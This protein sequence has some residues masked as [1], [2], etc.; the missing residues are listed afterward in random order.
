MTD[1]TRRRAV[2]TL[3]ATL[4][5]SSLLALLPAST[6]ACSCA[7]PTS[8][9]ETAK[10]P[11]TVIFSG[12][13]LA[14]GRPDVDVA[15][16][17]WFKGGAGPS[18]ALAAD[19]FNDQGG[20]ADCRVPYPA[21]GTSWIFV[22][23]LVPETGAQ[24]HTNLCSLQGRIDTP[25]GQQL[26]AS[27]VATFGEGVSPGH[28]PPASHGPLDAIGLAL[29]DLAPVAVS[30]A[31]VGIAFAGLALVLRRRDGDA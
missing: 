9:D 22:A 30:V 17:R 29:G 28:S 1:R 7:R 4:A 31:V 8:I 10:D 6:F 24:P 23:Y 3:L 20:G 12:T 15:V 18:T 21:A 5:A 11:N 27:A 26:L 13:I 25:E 2:A 16:D 14:T 19:G